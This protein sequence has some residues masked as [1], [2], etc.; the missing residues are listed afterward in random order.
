[1]ILSHKHTKGMHYL[2]ALL[3][4]VCEYLHIWHAHVMM[5]TGGQRSAC[6]SQ[7]LPLFVSPGDETQLIT[8][9][10]KCPYLLSHLTE[11]GVYIFAKN[12]IK[13]MG[14]L[15]RFILLRMYNVDMTY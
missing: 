3:L 10:G 4:S 1:M 5:C 14:V 2:H 13:V 12:P 11:P 7:L 9:S 15:S 8:L 6:R